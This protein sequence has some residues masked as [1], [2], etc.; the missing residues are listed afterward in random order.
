M[1]HKLQELVIGI[2]VTDR[3][4]FKLKFLIVLKYDASI[5]LLLFDFVS[6]TC[7]LELASIQHFNMI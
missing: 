5:E 6:F 3:V 7:V 4:L 2:K 1:V